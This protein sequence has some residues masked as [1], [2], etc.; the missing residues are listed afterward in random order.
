MENN[1]GMCVLSRSLLQEGCPIMSIMVWVMTCIGFWERGAVVE[2]P[3]N[4][5]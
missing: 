3:Q 2:K 1:M 5:L 4:G